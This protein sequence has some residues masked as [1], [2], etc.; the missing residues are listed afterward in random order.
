[1]CIKCV[2]AADFRQ[3]Y[4]GFDVPEIT[5]NQPFFRIFTGFLLCIKYDAIILLIA[6]L[7]EK[8]L[9]TLGF[10]WGVCIKCV[11]FLSFNKVPKG[12]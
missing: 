2:F 1:M 10:S 9:K 4:G 11:S 7:Y 8:V 5:S 6:L 12:L 3:F